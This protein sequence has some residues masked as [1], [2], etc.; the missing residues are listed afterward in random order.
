[1]RL[2]RLQKLKRKLLAGCVII[3]IASCTTT[4]CNCPWS[5]K[6]DPYEVDQDTGKF[7]SS[8][9]NIDFLDPKVND[10]TCFEKD[11]ISELKFNIERLK[12]K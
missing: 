7:V 4:P 11:N 1:M 2:K 10:L 5:W 3:L 9:S 8:D 6:A 12:L